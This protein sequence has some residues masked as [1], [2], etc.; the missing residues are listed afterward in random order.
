MTLTC[1][2]FDKKLTTLSRCLLLEVKR[3]HIL[4]LAI[5]LLNWAIFLYNFEDIGRGSCCGL[6]IS[7]A[8]D[9]S[10]V[11]VSFVPF[12]KPILPFI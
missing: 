12:C 7:V 11:F 1:H 5:C 3:G 8:L 9:I 6:A 2:K 4:P 10:D